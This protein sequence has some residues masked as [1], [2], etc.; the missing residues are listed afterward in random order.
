MRF[1]DVFIQRPV[2]AIVLGAVMLLLGLQASTQLSLRQFPEVEKSVIFVHTVY[3]GASARTV[4][5][6]VTAPLQ[7]RI[8]AAKGVEYV[9]SESNPSSSEIKVYVRLGEN[10]T[11]VLSEVI[12]KVNEA[13]FEL[14]RDVEDPVVTNRT[15]DDA[16]MYMALLSDQMSVQQVADYG[17]RTIQPVLNTVEGVGEARL[18]GGGMFAMRIWLNPAR[19][20]AS[21]REENPSTVRLK[22][23]R[24][25]FA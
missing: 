10:S 15:G 14:P 23:P 12:T 17:L 8:A 20:A 6:F 9:T 13:R 24:L 18:L 1:T 4:Q 25:I 7:R 5:G 19:M 21:A 2:V 3:P 11:E 22:V 16:M